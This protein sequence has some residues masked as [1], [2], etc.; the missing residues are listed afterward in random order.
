MKGS[1][2]HMFLLNGRKPAGLMRSDRRGDG[3][4]H[5]NGL[6]TH[7]GSKGVG[8]ALIAG[9][10]NDSL[11]NGGRG[12]VRL[13]YFDTASRNAYKALGFEQDISSNP[14]DMVL[15]PDKH[16]N[17]WHRNEDGTYKLN[18]PAPTMET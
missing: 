13:Q 15:Y 18:K 1:I 10:V 8:G 2:K 5:I 6:V 4:V 7:P 3:S 11:E 16:P 9:A 17:L 12:V 14:V